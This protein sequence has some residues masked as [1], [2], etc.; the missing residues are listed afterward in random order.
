MIKVAVFCVDI[1][2]ND[3]VLSYCNF[4]PLTLAIIAPLSSQ[5]P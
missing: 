3:I 5:T 4:E 1:S 2:F